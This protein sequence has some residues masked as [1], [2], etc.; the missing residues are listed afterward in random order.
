[1]YGVWFSN[2]SKGKTRLSWTDVGI[3]S[4]PPRPGTINVICKRHGPWSVPRAE[5]IRHW[6][7]ARASKPMT[8]KLDEESSWRNPDIW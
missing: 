4:D 6:H 1:M 2:M 3:V 7:E 8:V 5:M